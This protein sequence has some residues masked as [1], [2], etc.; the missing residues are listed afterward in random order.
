METEILPGITMRQATPDDTTTFAEI[1][2]EVAHWLWSRGIHQWQPGMWP[3]EWIRH[4]IARGDLYVAVE[5]GAVIGTVIIQSTDT[6]IW[7]ETANAAGYVHGLRVRRSAAGRGIGLALLCWAEREIAARGNRLARL[8]RL[9]CMAENSALCAYYERA[10]YQRVGSFTFHDGDEPYSVALFEKS[11]E[12][13][14]ARQGMA[15]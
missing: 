4:A 15:R 11:F 7:G 5:Q 3:E 2:Q 13:S 14:E 12:G 9:D 6:K 8:A 10:G 1:H